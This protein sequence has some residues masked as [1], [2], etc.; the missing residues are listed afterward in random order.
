[1]ES[2]DED[3]FANASAFNFA[4]SFPSN[5]MIS[6]STESPKPDSRGQ[7]GIACSGLDNDDSEGDTIPD[8]SNVFMRF[9]SILV[10]TLSL[11]SEKA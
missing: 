10:C 1:M 9:P 11:L 5:E 2:C 4:A 3:F 7:E 8:D 6:L